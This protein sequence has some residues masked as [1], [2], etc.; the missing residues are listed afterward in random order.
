MRSLANEEAHAKGALT[1]HMVQLTG[2]NERQ[3]RRELV[4]QNTRDH[5]LG[6]DLRGKWEE[7]EDKR[8]L[9]YVKLILGSACGK[10]VQ[11]KRDK[12][13]LSLASDAIYLTA[14]GVLPHVEAIADGGYRLLGE[15]VCFNF[16]T[17]DDL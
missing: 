3:A 6:V 5:A 10:T 9:S 4:V 7:E 15:Q 8:E 14:H 12:K 2:E 1:R 17:K 13:R 16:S 11:D